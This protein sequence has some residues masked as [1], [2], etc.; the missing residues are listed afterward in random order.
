MYNSNLDINIYVFTHVARLQ[1]SKISII[2]FRI[3]F[4]SGIQLQI[5]I[6][7][8]MWVF[9]VFTFSCYDFTYLSVAL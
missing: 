1:C 8:C 9:T 2:I 6:S 4:T 5:F 7:F 3:L